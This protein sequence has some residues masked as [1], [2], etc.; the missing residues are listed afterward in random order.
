VAVCGAVAL[1][2]DR[3]SGGEKNYVIESSYTLPVDVDVVGFFRM[4]IIWE[5]MEGGRHCRMEVRS[6]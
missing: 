4:H 6:R 1:D 3:H 5:G 2:I